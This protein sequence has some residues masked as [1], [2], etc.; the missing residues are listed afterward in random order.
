MQPEHLPTPPKMVASMALF[1][2]DLRE[3]MFLLLEL[4]DIK[5]YSHFVGLHGSSDH[6]KKEG[7]VSWPG[8]NEILFLIMTDTQ[9]E[10]F[11][12]VVRNFKEER[13]QA[14]GLLTF[15]WPLSEL[16]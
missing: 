8:T 6:G 4:A 1:D 2:S 10:H 15:S 3:E 12:E 11:R 14:P 16:F 7:S 5:N 9:T 13:E